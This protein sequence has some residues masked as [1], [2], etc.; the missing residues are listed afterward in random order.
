MHLVADESAADAVP[1][2]V[3]GAASAFAAGLLHLSFAEVA[4]EA[5][6]VA[7]PSARTLAESHSAPATLPWPRVALRA[8]NSATM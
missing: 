6:A 4:A 1:V 5:A 2:V 7:S 3:A 8:I